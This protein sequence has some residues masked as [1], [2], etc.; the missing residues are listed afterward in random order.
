M[1]IAKSIRIRAI[2]GGDSARMPTGAIEILDANVEFLES[3][4]QRS[5]NPDHLTTCKIIIPIAPRRVQ[6]LH[7]R[8]HCV[9]EKVAITHGPCAAAAL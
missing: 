5:I 3:F 4:K 6:I 2:R 8:Y 9:Q 1:A 7:V